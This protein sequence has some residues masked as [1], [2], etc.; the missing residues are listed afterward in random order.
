MELDKQ[1]AEILSCDIT[2]RPP[3]AAGIAEV[4]PYV[5]NVRAHQGFVIVDFK[6]AGE[7]AV[8]SFI[9]AEQLCCDKLIWT[10]EQHNDFL[11][12]RITGTEAQIAIVSGWFAAA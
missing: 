10:L 3:I 11:R 2:L 7:I 6:L 9:A 4:L 12:L 8:G 1:S 5:F